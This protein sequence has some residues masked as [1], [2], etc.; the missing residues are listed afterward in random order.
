VK[1]PACKISP[2]PPPSRGLP[3]AITADLRSSDLGLQ[4]IR[5]FSFLYRQVFFYIHPTKRDSGVITLK[6]VNIKF[7]IALKKTFCSVGRALTEE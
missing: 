2:A 5:I 4:T 6:I 3:R 1:E 7:N